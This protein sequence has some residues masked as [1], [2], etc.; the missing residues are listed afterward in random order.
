MPPCSLRISG[1]EQQ[2]SSGSAVGSLY[3]GKQVRWLFYAPS[4]YILSCLFDINGRFLFSVCIAKGWQLK[5]KNLLVKRGRHLPSWRRDTIKVFKIGKF[6]GTSWIWIDRF[7]HLVHQ[8]GE[9]ETLWC[10][11]CP[12][13]G[14]CQLS[15]WRWPT[16]G[17]ASSLIISM[18]SPCM[19][20]RPVIK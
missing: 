12:H 20:G 4:R 16:R 3:R 19:G 2:G 14:R 10:N 9:S 5:M 18:E 6:A 17:L 1:Q 13:P 8:A 15:L 7:C 11:P